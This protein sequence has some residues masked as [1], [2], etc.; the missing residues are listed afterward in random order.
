MSVYDLSP[1]TS[2]SLYYAL[3]NFFFRIE[4]FCTFHICSLSFCTLLLSIMYILY[5]FSLFIIF[6]SYFHSVYSSTPS[7]KHIFFNIKTLLIC[8]LDILHKLTINFKVFI[9]HIELGGWTL[10]RCSR[11]IANAIRCCRA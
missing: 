5:H 1:Y 3:T 6:W 11:I 2:Y 8:K 9:S 7:Y 10:D 4:L